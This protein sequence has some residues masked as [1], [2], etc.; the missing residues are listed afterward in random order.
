MKSSAAKIQMTSFDDLFQVDSGNGE[1]VLEMPLEE[2]YT[3]RNHPYHIQDDDKMQEMAESVEKYGVLLP[4]IV[5][6]RN[7][8]GYEI[9]A[10]HRRKF[11]CKRIGKRTMPVLVREMDDDTATILMVDSNIQR[12]HVLPSEKAWAYKMKLEALKHQGER[13]DLT[14]ARAV[15]KLTARE[16]V[17]Q[18]A[19]EK[20]GMAVTR[21]I[22]LT[23][24]IPPLLELVDNEKLSVS[25][26]AD[27]ISD[28]PESTQTEL[29]TGMQAGT[30]L[31]IPAA[32]QLMKIRRHYK[33]GNLTPAVIDAVLSEQRPA[34]IK[35]TIKSDKLKQYFPQS[36]TAEQMEEVIFSLLAEWQMQHK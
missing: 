1:R 24:L 12:E 2:L 4:G 32:A 10:G 5:R 28:L 20:S 29:F 26:A 19:G 7:E 6:P 18:D 13:N 30:V 22:A 3:F 16:K 21:Y 25:T 15:P 34:P 35:V 11:A 14:L 31:L 27:Y 23:R 33:E 17:A 36:Y 8:G 9:I